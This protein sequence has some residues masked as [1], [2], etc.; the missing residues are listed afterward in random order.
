MGSGIGYEVTNIST[1]TTIMTT[2]GKFYGVC[3][4]PKT[5]GAVKVSVF[6]AKTTGQGTQIF[7]AYASGS[8]GVKSELIE[9][10]IACGTGLFVEAVCTSGADQVVV[11]YGGV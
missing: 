4:I 5:T 11:F 9:G 3:V 1:N 2:A 6:D 7:G 8:S 10:G